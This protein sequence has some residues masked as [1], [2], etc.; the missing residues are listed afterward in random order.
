MTN[1]LRVSLV[2]CC[3]LG[4]GA[5]AQANADAP[6][7]ER[8]AAKLKRFIEILTSTEDMD[9]AGKTVV[10]EKLVHAS[11]LD[12]NEPRQLN[13]DSMRFAFKTI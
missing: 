1:P 13:N 12:K 11:K 9:A 2:L 7:D 5:F 10:A 8:G 4:G 6:P 3:L